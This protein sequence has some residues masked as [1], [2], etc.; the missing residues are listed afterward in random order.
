MKTRAPVT[1]TKTARSLAP[2]PA[3]SPPLVAHLDVPLAFSDPS[4]P[5]EHTLAA[6]DGGVVTVTDPNSSWHL[7]PSSR[8]RMSVGGGLYSPVSFELRTGGVRSRLFCFLVSPTG[9]FELLDSDDC[10]EGQ[11]VAF[12]DGGTPYGIA[13]GPGRDAPPPRPYGEPSCRPTD[14]NPYACYDDELSAVYRDLDGVIRVLAGLEGVLSAGLHDG[15]AQRDNIMEPI[16]HYGAP[17][18]GD[19]VFLRFTRAAEGG[20]TVGSFLGDQVAT[21]FVSHD[22]AAPRARHVATHMAGAY[23]VLSTADGQ[24]VLRTSPDGRVEELSFQPGEVEV[25]RLAEVDLA[26]GELLG[27]ALPWGDRLLV[28]T[29]R[30]FLGVTSFDEGAQVVVKRMGKAY[31]GFVEPEASP[32]PVEEGP[33]YGLDFRQEGAEVLLCWPPG[34]GEASPTGW[35]LGG[36]PASVVTAGDD[37]ALLIREGAVGAPYDRMNL[38]AVGTIPGAGRAALGMSPVDQDFRFPDCAPLA[39]GGCVAL[40]GSYG[41]GLARW[42]PHDLRTRL[43]PGTEIPG[44]AADIEADGRGE[45]MW[46]LLRRQEAYARELVLYDGARRLALSFDGGDELIPVQD[47]GVILMDGETRTAVDA[48]GATFSLAPGCEAMDPDGALF[49]ADGSCCGSVNPQEA[50]APASRLV[51]C[52]LSDQASALDFVLPLELRAEEDRLVSVGRADLYLLNPRGLIHLQPDGAVGARQALS[53]VGVDVPRGAQVDYLVGRGP[54][55]SVYAMVAVDKL[56]LAQVE[57]LALTPEGPALVDAP[58]LGSLTASNPLEDEPQ[59][60]PQVA[61]L[62]TGEG[63][64]LFVDKDFIVLPTGLRVPR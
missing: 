8:Y 62:L 31:A 11:G 52:W 29:N 53:D 51:R 46:A 25:T 22:G 36:E 44:A 3:P 14:Q 15:T 4:D 27:G 54:E 39:E 40:E 47:G 10:V 61:D 26:E 21:A 24:R 16:L 7:S 49:Y 2:S 57:L 9:D 19:S 37:C 28:V 17:L 18:I 45:G 55:G 50:S 20:V 23:S 64:R 6:L 48:D 56:Y 33:L 38:E 1:C 63:A 12:D 34:H 35:T 42:T 32:A 60:P 59:L 41:A 5:I 43:V 13:A 30:G 58:R